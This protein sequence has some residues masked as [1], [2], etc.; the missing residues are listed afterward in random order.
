[1]SAKNSVKSCDRGKKYLS[2]FNFHDRSC[3]NLFKRW[4]LTSKHE[5]LKSNRM[6]CD[7]SGR[8]K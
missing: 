8:S 3:E 5:R 2:S 1:M 4:N 6:S 7:Q